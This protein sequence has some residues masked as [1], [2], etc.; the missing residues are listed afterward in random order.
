[1][2]YN[3]VVVSAIHQHESATGIHMSPHSGTSLTSPTLFYPSSVLQSMIACCVLNIIEKQKY[4]P[5]TSGSLGLEN[6]M[7]YYLKN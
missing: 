4:E 3:I 2:L 1:M 5:M 6:I 7:P